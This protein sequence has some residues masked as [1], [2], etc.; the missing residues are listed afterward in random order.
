M[1]TG[2]LI[3]EDEDDIREML[4]FKFGRQYDVTAVEDGRACWE[5]LEDHAEDPPAVVLLDVMMAGLDGFR[6]LDKIADDE[7]FDDVDVVMLT[8]RGAE[9]DV[10]AALDRGATDY[11]TKPFS[12]DDL[13][14]RV[15]ELV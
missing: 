13:R 4:A 2:I 15:D 7:R 11:V 14:D 10:D 8:S 5:Y 9:A 6:V 3:A 1:S 12:P